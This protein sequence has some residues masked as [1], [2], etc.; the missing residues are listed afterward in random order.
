MWQ[1]RT[2]LPASWKMLKISLLV[3]VVPP[4]SSWGYRQPRAQGSVVRRLKNVL[5]GG[6]SGLWHLPKTL[7]F[8]DGWV[9]VNHGLSKGCPSQDTC[10][11][12]PVLGHTAWLSAGSLLLLCSPQS[13]VSCKCSV[14]HNLRQHKC[15]IQLELQWEFQK[16]GC[17]YLYWLDS[18][19][20]TKFG[21]R[22]VMTMKGHEPTAR[23]HQENSP[24]FPSKILG[25]Q[26]V[27]WTMNIDC[28]GTFV[29]LKAF[30]NVL[31]KYPAAISIWNLRNK[32]TALFSCGLEKC[33]SK[34][35]PSS[36]PCLAA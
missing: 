25:L 32:S 15:C 19:P 21:M 28:H 13:E 36:A 12:Q 3:S 30:T 22:S 7:M 14:N 18:N 24:T 16:M 8:W 6:W 11:H 31:Y 5:Q 27:C 9:V 29:L 33:H 35:F 1:G 4:H 20:L 26:L 34:V 10:A 23:T 2:F 17:Y